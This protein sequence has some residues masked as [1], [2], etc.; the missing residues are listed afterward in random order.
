MV[1]KAKILI[2]IQGIVTISMMNSKVTRI[3]GIILARE[4]GIMVLIIR[5]NHTMIIFMVHPVVTKEMD[6]TTMA[7][8]NLHHGKVEDDVM[9]QDLMVAK[10]FLEMKVWEKLLV[11]KGIKQIVNPIKSL[12]VRS[13]QG[14]TPK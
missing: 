12:T 5:V 7:N 2:K 11:M 14:M 8:N 3:V 9:S 1:A 6:F 4:K 13:L 10:A